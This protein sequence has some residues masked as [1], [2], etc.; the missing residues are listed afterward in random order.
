MD[1]VPLVDTFDTAVHILLGYD[2]YDIDTDWGRDLKNE[3]SESNPSRGFHA[4][5]EMMKAIWQDEG[6]TDISI[7]SVA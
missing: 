5:P 4:G 3:V 6:R 1:R 7:E 2:E